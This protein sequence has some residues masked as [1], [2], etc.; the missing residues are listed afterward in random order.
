MDFKKLW[1]GMCVLREAIDDLNTEEK[2]LCLEREGVY[3][4]DSTEFDAFVKSVG[5]E[6][7]VFYEIVPLF[8]TEKQ[9]KKSLTVNGLTFYTYDRS[10]EAKRCAN[11]LK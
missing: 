4:Y 1:N 6:S 10:E 3:F 9:V 2:L 11:F 5:F 8:R 7:L